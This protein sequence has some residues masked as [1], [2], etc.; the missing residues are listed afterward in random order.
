M[1]VATANF[2]RFAPPQTPDWE[3]QRRAV[4]MEMCFIAIKFT[5]VNIR[6]C[7]LVLR[8]LGTYWSSRVWVRGLIA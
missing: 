2:L 3:R 8:S 7:H 1:H 4:K 5:S 6:S